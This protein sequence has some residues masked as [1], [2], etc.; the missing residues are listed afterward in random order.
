MISKVFVLFNQV[1][2]V[3]RTLK[4]INLFP[5][6]PEWNEGSYF[7][8]ARDSSRFFDSL[9]MTMKLHFFFQLFN[10]HLSETSSTSPCGIYCAEK[11]QYEQNKI[12][13]RARPNLCYGQIC[14]FKRSVTCQFIGMQYFSERQGEH[15]QS[16]GGT[17][18]MVRR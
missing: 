1:K 15:Y 4:Y 14:H 11:I 8:G 5:C 2:F 18:G 6:H 17:I 9:R 3:I 12:P 16:L 13:E 10:N 7:L